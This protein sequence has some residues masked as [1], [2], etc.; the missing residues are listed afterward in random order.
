MK[1]NSG[2]RSQL[3]ENAA[4]W[5]ISVAASTMDRSF[6]TP[7]TL[8]NNRTIMGQA[9]STGHKEIGFTSLACPEGKGLFASEGKGIII[10]PS[11]S[12]I[13]STKTP[14]GVN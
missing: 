13:H 1:G 5:I 9:M 6:P 8:G 3:V 10:N 12:Q 2:P 4:P 14:Y 7:I 11:R